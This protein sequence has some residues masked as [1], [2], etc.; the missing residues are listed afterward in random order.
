[1][2]I[3]KWNHFIGVLLLTV[4]PLN[5]AIA[6]EGVDQTLLSSIVNG[7][8]RSETNQARD[9]FR[10]PQQTLEFFG[11]NPTMTVVEIWPGK[12]WYTEI[13]AP[14]TKQEGKFIAAGFPLNSGPKWR[15]NMQA[16]YLNW[17][18]TTP[19]L[20]EDVKVIEL[21]PPS[22]WTLGPDESVDAVLTFRNVHNWLKGDYED[23]MFDAFYR[24]L[25]PGGILGVTDHRAM[26]NTE[27]KTMNKSGYLNQDLVIILAQ[28]AGFILE[29]TAEINAN[30]F[31]TKDHPKGVWTLPPT[32]RLGDKDQKHY[33]AIGESDRMTL[34]FR[35][36]E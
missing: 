13:L 4:I 27:L 8:H 3:T 34:R 35:K 30:P 25:K 32:L 17:L 1:M 5:V 21:G 28:K 26:P 23:K 22:F 33:L 31:D 36:P 11:I 7:D 29:E 10:H 20:Y 2:N 14:F 24:V 19:D 12:G 15:Q 18:A 16:E 6:D 9:R